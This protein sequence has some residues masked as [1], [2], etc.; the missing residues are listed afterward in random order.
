MWTL[1][2]FY[3]NYIIMAYGEIL[4]VCLHLIQITDKSINF[5]G[6]ISELRARSRGVPQGSVLWLVSFLFCINDLPGAL[7]NI[8]R[9]L[10]SDDLSFWLFIFIV[11][12]SKYFF[13]HFIQK[14]VVYYFP[15]FQFSTVFVVLL[16]KRG[17]PTLNV[18]TPTIPF[19]R[20]NLVLLE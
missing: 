16:R 2:Y 5:S 6:T 18:P 10:F 13:T 8:D 15:M 1:K 14:S 9:I 7:D 17:D 19:Y 12:F 4:R 20:K 11:D 3:L